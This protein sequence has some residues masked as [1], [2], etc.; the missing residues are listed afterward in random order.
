M[1]E[2]PLQLFMETTPPTKFFDREMAKGIIIFFNIFS[3]ALLIPALY[4]FIFAAIDIV[5]TP[6]STM[7]FRKSLLLEFLCLTTPFMILFSIP[8]TWIFYKLSKYKTATFMSLLPFG[9]ILFFRI[10]MI[11]ANP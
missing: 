5:D 4:V 1:T 2:T 8:S 9:N 10:C 7:T 11:L 3:I 6:I